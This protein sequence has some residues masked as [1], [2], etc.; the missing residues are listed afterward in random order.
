LGLSGQTKK[1]FVCKKDIKQNILYVC[2]EQ[3][4]E[5]CLSST[6]CEVENFNWISGIPKTNIVKIRFRHRQQFVKGQFH[7]IKNKV[8]LK[9]VSTLAVTPGQFAVLYQ[10]HTCLGG[11]IVNKLI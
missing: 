11:G 4:K 10:N 1:Y 2:D 8:Y 3:H 6:Q 9:Y 7:I 5:K